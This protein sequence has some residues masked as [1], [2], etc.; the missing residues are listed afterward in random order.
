MQTP[1]TAE[2][3]LGDRAPGANVRTQE[4]NNPDRQLRCLVTDAGGIRS[5][6]A[7]MSSVKGGEKPP[8]HEVSDTLLP[9]KA[10]KLQ[11]LTTVPQTDTGARDEYS[12]ALER[13]QEK[14]LGKLIP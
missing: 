8:R 14:E 10:T 12:K 13:T 6:N 1:N 7:D 5:A 11:L 2:Y 9:G 4:G 3:S